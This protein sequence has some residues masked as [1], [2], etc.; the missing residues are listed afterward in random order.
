[1]LLRRSDTLPDQVG[2]LLDATKQYR[3][4]AQRQ[5]IATKFDKTFLGNT[6]PV[7]KQAQLHVVD[8]FVCA[9]FIAPAIGDVGFLGLRFLLFGCAEK[10]SGGKLRAVR[11]HNGYEHV[12]ILVVHDVPGG[13]LAERVADLTIEEAPVLPR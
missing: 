5:S 1:M 12:S 6:D 4:C 9:Q 8:Y 3:R 11:T 2:T 13:I 10:V 7:G